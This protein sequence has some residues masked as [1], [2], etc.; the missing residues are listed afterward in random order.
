MEQAWPA[1]A[2]P[3]PAMFPNRLRMGHLSMANAVMT[4]PSEAAQVRRPSFVR[5][6]LFKNLSA[7]IAALPMII[8][9]LVVFVGCSVW[10]IV[11][12]FT[13]SGSLPSGKFVGWAQYERLF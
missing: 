5:N 9:V 4:A 2:N 12:S 8:T 10:S 7:K 1:W 13:N 6:L 11:Y 3:E